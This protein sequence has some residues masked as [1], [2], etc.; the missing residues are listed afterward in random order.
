MTTN[1]REDLKR[2]LKDPELKKEYD[3]L[4]GEV[5]V[6]QAIIDARKKTNLTQKE[7]SDRSGIDQAD[8]SRLEN[9]TTN[10]TIK[11]LQKLANG[12]DMDLELRFV[13]KTK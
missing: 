13:P 4:D 7:L 9:G 1:F 8:I 6:I 11:L 12:L 10:P 2:R 3:A 5:K